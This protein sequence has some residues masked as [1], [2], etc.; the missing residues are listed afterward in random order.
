VTSGPP[1]VLGNLD[2]E[3]R[4]HGA[5]L[6]RLVLERISAAACL[7]RY[8]FD[9]PIALWL[10]AA[11]APARVVDLPGGPPLALH[12]LRAGALPRGAAGEPIAAWGAF[13]ERAIPQEP[14]RDRH[15]LSVPAPLS[16]ARA[17]NDRRFAAALADT[18]GVAPPGAATIASLD[19][20]RRHLEEGGAAASPT[21]QWICKAPLSAAGRDRV[22]F[23][24]P[25]S[26]P[27]A[28]RTARAAELRAE[29]ERA[30][31]R[32]LQRF[33]ALTFEPWLERTSDL[34][35]CAVVRPDGA[36]AQRPPHTLLTNL[37]GGFLGI[38]RH[39]PPLT[40]AQREEL[41]RVTAAAG[42]ALHAAGYAGPYNLDAF[43]HRS[44]EGELI[45]RP[46]CEINA[47]ISFGWIAAALAERHGFAELGFGPPPPGAT[48]LIAPAAAGDRGD[49]A[50]WAR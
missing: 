47:R 18:L 10:P 16:I 2:C 23:E 36:I 43:V 34:G 17:V 27:S 29:T 45:L 32:L 22:I 8:L 49:G 21:G 25:L 31:A 11:V 35:V 20:L 19:Q 40:A 38:S 15:R 46:L 50:A 3:A 26:G 4:W 5:V 7:M 37:R 13:S 9:E 33:G 42:R 1:T 28:S 48:L 6:P 39:P 41:A 24:G 14:A 30:L 44:R 12:V